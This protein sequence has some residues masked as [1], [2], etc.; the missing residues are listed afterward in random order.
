MKRRHRCATSMA[1]A[2]LEAVIA[3]ARAETAAG[4][5]R[6]AWSLPVL[7]HPCPGPRLGP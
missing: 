1:G 2:A 3:P 7:K 4:E 6:R 5:L